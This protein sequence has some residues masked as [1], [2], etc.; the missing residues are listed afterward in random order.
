MPCCGQGARA[1]PAPT[2][3]SRPPATLGA[4]LPAAATALM[5]HTGTRA[6]SAVGPVTGVR[7]RF[8]GPGARVA[9]DRRDLAALST[10]P[11]LRVV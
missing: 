1:V 5:E 11:G 7:Y 9:V 6:L 4:P 10:I 3:P 2:M 8:G